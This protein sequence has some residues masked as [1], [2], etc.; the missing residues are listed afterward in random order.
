MWVRGLETRVHSIVGASGCF[1]ATRRRLFDDHF[2][3]ELSRDFASALIARERGYRSVSVADALCFVPRTRSL[4]AEFRRK[5]RTMARGLATLEYKRHLMSPERY[6]LFA[7]MLM[8]HKLA[9]WLFYVAL[10]FSLAGLV[11]LALT[12]WPARVALAA[13]AVGG[14]AGVAALV[15]PEGKRVPAMLA[16]PGFLFISN[17]AGV[18]AWWRYLSGERQAVW[19]PTRRPGESVTPGA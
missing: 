3:E 17:L 6:G 14:I 8:S 19:E 1:F 18:L 11:L 4:A 13:F 5:I 15:W 16:L 12:F 7:W 10:P 9:R 2:P